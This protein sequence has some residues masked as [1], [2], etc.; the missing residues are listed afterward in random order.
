MNNPGFKR[1][2]YFGASTVLLFLLVYLIS[3]KALFIPGLWPLTGIV[4]PLVFMVLA[5]RDTRNMQDGFMSFGEAL[6]ATFLTFVIGSLIYTL[7][8]YIMMNIIDTS[9]LEY[10]KEIALEAMDNYSELLG[11][12]QVD[13][14]KDQLEEGGE[15]GLGSHMM[16][17][18]LL[19]IAP[20]FLYS[21]IISA[22]TKRNYTP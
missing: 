15:S 10:G 4:L 18:A 12:E 16:Q 6:S 17:W 8:R 14:F 3:K 1:G 21:L 5:A 13:Q 22:I 2:L 20:G 7:F 9:L 11:E 19:L